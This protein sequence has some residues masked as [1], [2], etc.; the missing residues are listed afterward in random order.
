MACSCCSP[1]KEGKKKKYE[2]YEITDAARTLIR[3]EEIKAN[4]VLSKLVAA[5]LDKQSKA[6]AKAKGK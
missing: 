4:K 6:I 2:E 1:V 3:A 5:E